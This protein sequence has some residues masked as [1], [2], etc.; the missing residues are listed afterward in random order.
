MDQLLSGAALIAGRRASPYRSTRGGGANVGA[1]E[2]QA[3][4]P[5]AQRGIRWWPAPRSQRETDGVQ[6]KRGCSTRGGRRYLPP[7][8]PNDPRSVEILLGAGVFVGA[9]AR[10][11]VGARARVAARQGG[12]PP[13]VFRPV[14]SQRRQG[15]K[16][17]QGDRTFGGCYV[18]L[19]RG[20]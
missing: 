1:T 9:W 12:H 14:L 6:V 8:S 3:E 19:R 10:V 5:V 18:S 4:R 15:D 7:L 17:L 16:T 13:D 2:K 11:R 20:A